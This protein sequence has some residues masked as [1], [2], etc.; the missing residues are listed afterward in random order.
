MFITIEGFVKNLI[1]NK[2][3]QRIVWNPF[4]MKC[5]FH[6][7]SRDFNKEVYADY[8]V[9]YIRT[10]LEKHFTN[11]EVR[12]AGLGYDLLEILFDYVMD[13]LDKYQKNL[14]RK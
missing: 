2:D 12:Y 11:V 9:E 13:W 8:D 7:N 6:L 5:E 3:M 10:E 14:N 4:N 1:A